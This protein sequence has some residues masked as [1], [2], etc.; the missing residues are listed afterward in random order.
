MIKGDPFEAGVGL[1]K[2]T[3]SL[4]KNTVAG[5]FGSASTITSTVS[6]GLLVLT[7]VKIL[8]NTLGRGLHAISRA[9]EH[10]KEAKTLW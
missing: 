7:N 1:T 9:R 5:T 10:G 6:K 4:I 8:N 2:G 3:G